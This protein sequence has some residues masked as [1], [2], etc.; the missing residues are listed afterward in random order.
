MIP[1]VPAYMLNVPA[2]NPST[3]YS[4]DIIKK[5]DIPEA[6]LPGSEGK[7]PTEIDIFWFF[8]KSTALESLGGCIFSE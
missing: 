5:D 6:T 1:E 3:M 4:N 2:V 7:R 8:S